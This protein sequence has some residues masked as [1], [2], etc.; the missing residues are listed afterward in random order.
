MIRPGRARHRESGRARSV[1]TLVR[2]LA[3]AIVLALVAMPVSSA[4]VHAVLRLDPDV[5]LGAEVASSGAAT[6]QYSRSAIQS[7]LSH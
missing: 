5:P 7:P 2:T 1:R 4:E 6:R 3:V